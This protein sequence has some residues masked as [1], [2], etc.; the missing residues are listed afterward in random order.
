MDLLKKNLLDLEY[1][2]YLQYSTTTIVAMFTFAIGI[3]IAI[4]TD[5][6]T[7]Q[8]MI[9]FVIILSFMVYAFLF[10]LLFR[11]RERMNGILEE[12]LQLSEK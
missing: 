1:Q 10:W 7:R 11:F 2:K 4:F 8:E 9:I 3:I 6:L 12:I 5:Q